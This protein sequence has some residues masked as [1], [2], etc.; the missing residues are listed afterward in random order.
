MQR[1]Q[2]LP[3]NRGLPQSCSSRQLVCIAH[4]LPSCRAC[5]ADGDGRQP[6]SSSSGRPAAADG[7]QVAIPSHDGQ[8]IYAGSRGALVA[9]RRDDLSLVD[10]IKASRSRQ[11]QAAG[12]AA[13]AKAAATGPSPAVQCGAVQ[14]SAVQ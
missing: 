10:V 3:T 9:F 7:G 13:A 12:A 8:L 6:S 4:T 2:S 11:W 5:C 1:T 14:C